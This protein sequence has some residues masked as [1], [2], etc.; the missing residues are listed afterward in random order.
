[1]EIKLNMHTLFYCNMKKERKYRLNSTRIDPSP[2]SGLF[3]C[4]IGEK[5]VLPNNSHNLILCS[6]SARATT[7]QW[8]DKRHYK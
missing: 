6:N 7:L 2:C 4:S 8:E 5:D 3:L 1:M